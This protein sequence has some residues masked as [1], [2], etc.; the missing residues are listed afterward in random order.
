MADPDPER[1]VASIPASALRA[2][3]RALS[4]EAGAEAAA[5]ALQAAGVAT[6]DM[7]FESLTSS[8]A[9]A[10]GV[11]DLRRLPTDEFWEVVCEF[12]SDLGWGTLDQKAVHPGIAS[13]SAPDW[14]EADPAQAAPGPR[15]FFATGMLSG[16]LGGIAGEPVGVLEVECRST[17]DD[18]CRFLFGGEAALARI[19]VSLEAGRDLSGT[20]ELLS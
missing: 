20:L 15:C 1:A 11:E 7:L 5:R 17:G 2:L 16:L 10:I 3:H 18:H 4:H 9:A 14:I 8:E 13:L 19:R 12:L 6:G